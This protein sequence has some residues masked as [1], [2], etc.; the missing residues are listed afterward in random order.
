MGIRLNNYTAVISPTV[1][2]DVDLNY[3]P[4]SIWIDT[5][6]LKEYRCLSNGNG[7]AVWTETTQGGSSVQ[8]KTTFPLAAY[9]AKVNDSAAMYEAHR[10]LTAGGVHGAADNTNAIAVTNPATTLAEAMAL[11]DDHVAKHN[12]HRVLTAGG[13][14][15]AADN[16]YV[17][18]A[19]TNISDAVAQSSHMDNTYSQHRQLT[20]GAV[21]GAV[22]AVNVISTLMLDDRP[23]ASDD[24]SAGYA[25]GSTWISWGWN[26]PTLEAVIYSCVDASPGAAV[27][28]VVS[29]PPLA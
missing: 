29:G 5:V 13:V 28:G 19:I 11:H 21:H 4:G 20:A 8:N 7:T 18:V 23:G 17:P 3:E 12:A 1:N 22:D 27:W 16:T 6:A 25:E 9:I 10:V 15:G 26:S 14:H 24:S 2:D